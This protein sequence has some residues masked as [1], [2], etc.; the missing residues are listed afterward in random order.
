MLPKG[1][2]I[3]SDHLI[4]SLTWISTVLRKTDYIT[5]ALISTTT[6]KCPRNSISHETIIGRRIYCDWLGDQVSLV[7]IVACV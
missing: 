3:V 7:Q 1:L 6:H 2:L 5:K 4:V